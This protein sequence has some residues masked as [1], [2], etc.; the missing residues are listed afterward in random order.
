MRPPNPLSQFVQSQI[1][2]NAAEADIRNE[3]AHESDSSNNR[4]AT[5]AAGLLKCELRLRRMEP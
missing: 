1:D 4:R 2:R 5:M 3:F